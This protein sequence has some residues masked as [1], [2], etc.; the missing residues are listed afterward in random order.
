M[1][2]IGD[3]TIYGTEGDDD[4]DALAGDDY[5]FGQYGDDTLRGGDGA[6]T[7]FGSVGVDELYGGQGDDV[8]DFDNTRDTVIEAFD[9]GLDTIYASANLSLPANVENVA[10][11]YGQGI[12]VY[13]NAGDNVM[14]GHLGADTLWAGDGNDSVTGGGGA[15]D[16][17]GGLGD[18]T[19]M[20]G[21]GN[22]VLRAGMGHDVVDG[23]EPIT[24]NLGGDVL[25]VDYSALNVPVTV[26]M[27]AHTVQAGVN[28]VDFSGIE[29]FFF[30]GGHADDHLEGSAKGDTL[31]GGSGADTMA[32]GLGYDT[33]YVDS[34]RDVVI[35]APGSRAY[36]L[37][38][39]YTSVSLV[40]FDNVDDAV[41]TGSAV[42]LTGTNAINTLVGSDGDNIL[43]GAAGS[44]TLMGSAGNDE[45]AGGT[46]D[47]ALYGDYRI[48][49]TAGGSDTLTGGLGDDFLTGGAGS[50]VFR[51]TRVVDSAGEPQT[52]AGFD[53]DRIAD[54]SHAEGDVID[55][56]GV[57]ANATLAGNQAFTFIG[58]TGFHHVAGE[59]R[60]TSYSY[61]DWLGDH[62]TVP[63]IE[64]DTDGDGAADL[65]IDFLADQKQDY[66]DSYTF[67]ASDFAL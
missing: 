13:G 8:Y 32:G 60:Q 12:R 2:T 33:Y 43:W 40:L 61:V 42:K 34:T 52:D 67:V 49:P 22:D 26:T 1:A 45:L 54:F 62:H 18:D 3:D 10:V 21:D 58:Q 24:V 6:D 27:A 64:A 29:S 19:L 59:L 47:D 30:A 20:G 9:E 55:V 39:V 25:H 53:F 51:I 48:P 57:D 4:I 7:L 28:R 63:M 17:A 44:D 14:T 38:R 23:G 31:D 16:L 56:S 50:D 11:A 15:D 65:R 37:D 41:L 35:E 46:G 5:V 36:A 66:L